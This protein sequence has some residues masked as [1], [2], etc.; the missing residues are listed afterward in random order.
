MKAFHCTC[1]Q[2]LFFHNSQCLQCGSTVAY[3]PGAR[4]LRA[5]VPSPDG[6]WTVPLSE[7]AEEA[8]PPRFRLCSHREHPATCNW[9]LPADALGDLCLSCRLTRVFPA[10]NRP[11]NTDRLHTLEVAKRRLLFSLLAFGLPLTSKA[12]DPVNGLAFDFKE[13][14]VGEPPVVIGHAGGV[15]TLNVEE[16]DDDYR[17]KHRESLRE[18]YRTVIGHLRHE[19]AHYYWDVLVRTSEWLPRFRELFGDDRQDYAS[20][21]Q[22]HY[23]QGPPPDW[24][25]RFISA[26]ASSHPWEDWAESWAHYLHLRATLET[27]TEFGLGTEGISLRVDPF[28]PE[29]LYLREP[30]ESGAAFLGWINA[31]VALTAVLNEVSRSMGQP[32]LYPFVLSVPTVTKLHFVHCVIDAAAGRG[33]PI[34][35][36]Q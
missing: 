9:L 11:R 23:T 27:V 4:T 21:L 18:P 31:W 26:Y 16:A 28:N 10:L 33:S 25:S 12:E 35:N 7:G 6:L 2:P 32:D 14:V 17:E 13:T 34:A 1:G 29:A 3:D 19:I 24:R 5:L 15:I 36:S 8:P 22:R 20:A 30:A